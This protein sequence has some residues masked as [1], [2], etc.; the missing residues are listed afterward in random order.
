MPKLP[1]AK[2]ELMISLMKNISSIASASN[3]IEGPSE[4]MNGLKM[5]ITYNGE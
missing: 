5:T 4:D 3:N 2:K 1:T